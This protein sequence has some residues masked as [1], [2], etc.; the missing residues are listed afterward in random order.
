MP[1]I[2]QSLGGNFPFG[3]GGGGP[4]TDMGPEMWGIV[5]E[6]D[7]RVQLQV[8]NVVL[9]THIG[10]ARLH[11]EGLQKIQKAMSVKASTAKSR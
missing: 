5:R 2:P 1:S 11:I 6:L 3:G 4:V 9:E 10:M 7:Q 8:L